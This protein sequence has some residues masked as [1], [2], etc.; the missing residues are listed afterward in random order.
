MTLLEL[1][2]FALRLLFV[3]L[4]AVIIGKIAASSGIET[5]G[6]ETDNRIDIIDIALSN[7]RT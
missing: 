6:D 5:S 7:S 4:P 3:S 1:P 2:V